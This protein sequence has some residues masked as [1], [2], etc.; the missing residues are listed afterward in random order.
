MKDNDDKTQTMLLP[1]PVGVVY[2]KNNNNKQT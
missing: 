1:D 2:N